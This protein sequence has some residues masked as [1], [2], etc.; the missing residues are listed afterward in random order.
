VFALADKVRSESYAAMQVLKRRGIKVYMLTGEA[1][2]VAKA[3]ANELGIG[4]FF[5]ELL[6]NQK[7]ERIKDLQQQRYRVA[8]VGDGINDASALA[9]A[10]VGIAIGASTDITLESADIVF[11]KNDLREVSKAISFPEEPIQ[12]CIRI[13]GGRRLQH[14]GNT[15]SCRSF[16]KVRHNC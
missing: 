15:I 1:S 7:A 16:Y 14:S 6:P 4:E 12:R 8:M 13:F 2:A 9:T 5:A 3:V 11:V 10:E